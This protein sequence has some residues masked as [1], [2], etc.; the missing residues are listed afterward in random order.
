MTKNTKRV[1][2]LEVGDIVIF[3]YCKVIDT[4]SKIDILSE[5]DYLISSVGIDE[6]ERYDS[7]VEVTYLG[8]NKEEKIM[9]I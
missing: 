3:P 4:V 9:E 5:W 8:N 6:P 1:D 2:E 7:C